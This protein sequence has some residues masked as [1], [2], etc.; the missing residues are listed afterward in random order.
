MSDAIQIFN[1]KTQKQEFERVMGE[2]PMRK[3]YGTRLG[4][5]LAQVLSSPWM[6]QV[7]GRYQS[8]ARSK[9]AIPQ[10]IKT[11][12]IPMNEFE[13][14]DFKSFNDFFIRKFKSGQRNYPTIASQMGAPAEGRYFAFDS[15]TDKTPLPIKGVTL[16]VSSLLGSNVDTKIFQGGPGFIARLCPV[17]YH[18]FHFPDSGK[19]LRQERLRG[20]LHSV[21]PIAL[22]AKGDIL[23]TNE[24]FL[25]IIETENFGKIAYLE[26]G[27]L[28]VGRIVQSHSPTGTFKRGD[29]KGYFLFGAS[30][31]IMV[32][33][34]GRW[35]L[36][37]DLIER[38]K[39]GVE[40]LV[41]LG[42]KIATSAR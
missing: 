28:C 11:F 19:I 25:S 6:S 7:Y 2:A 39:E 3:L 29:E 1:R 34:P 42:D 15:V 37:Q 26:V 16:N 8:S 23:F 22:K 38:T 9:R 30:T 4:M 24:R 18:R 36:D 33:E 10:F 35:I 40:T 27:A 41:R 21:N 14:E 5:Q 31:V 12:Q 13:S 32:G 17:D 20:P